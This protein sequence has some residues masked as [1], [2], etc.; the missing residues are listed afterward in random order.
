MEPNNPI[1][2]PVFNQPAQQPQYQQP[3]YP[4]QPYYGLP[5]MK[6]QMGFVE[7][8]KTVLI[9]KYCCFKG[10]ARRSEFWNWTLAY[11]L[12]S[13]VLSVFNTFMMFSRLEALDLDD[14]FSIYKSPGYIVIAL[15]G[16]ALF[17]PNLGV[18]I[19]RLHDTGRSGWWV[20]VPVIAYFPML[21]AALS[22]QTNPGSAMG[23]LAIMLLCGLVMLVIGIIILVWLCQDSEPQENEYGPS[24]KYS[25]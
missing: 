12:L 10:R 17:L 14:P 9:E 21:W 25:A 8:I 3:Q 24:P 15:V 11:V 2:P 22:V 16:L 4:Q 13:V 23:M 7:A 19:R 5:Q 18:T 6:P 20:W 1:Q